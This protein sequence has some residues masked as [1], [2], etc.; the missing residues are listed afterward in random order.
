MISGFSCSLN[1]LKVRVTM[2]NSENSNIL[3]FLF[4]FPN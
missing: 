2:L 3:L 4:K 1:P